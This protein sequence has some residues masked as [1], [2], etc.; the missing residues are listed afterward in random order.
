ML[1]TVCLAFA[2]LTTPPEADLTIKQNGEPMA[3][4]KRSEL[5]MS[6]L[7]LMDM[8]K[9]EPI[10]DKLAR[11]TYRPPHNAVIGRQGNIVQEQN[12]IRLDR[13][14]LC[15]LIEAYFYEGSPQTVE[16]PVLPIHPKVDGELL[17]SVREKQIGG[18]VTYYNA[19]NRKR[20]H[21][22]ALAAK[23][24]DS[25]VVFP[26]EVFSFNET[27][28]AR[29]RDKGYERATVIVRGELAEDIGGGICQVSSTLFN[30]IDRAGLQVVQRYSHSRRVAYVPSGRDATVSWGGPDFVFLNRYN[31]PVLI[32]AFAGNGALYVTVY[33]PDDL[34]PE[35]RQVPQMSRKL[36]E[37]IEL[38][39]LGE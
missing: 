32:R 31:Q 34:V 1:L 12:G 15:S 2:L 23:A 20:A 10:L 3:A 38:E 17:S 36:P 29:T 6:M 30:A 21:N 37:E 14:R 27:V 13:D 16:L 9:M 35:P 19:S 39:A 22:I 24:I 5:V 8:Q 4:I 28:G 11:L 25:A 26:G 18:Y 7:P 33:S